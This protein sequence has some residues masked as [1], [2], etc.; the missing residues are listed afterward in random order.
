M[1]KN[2]KVTDYKNN[3]KEIENIDL[4]PIVQE[5]KIEDIKEDKN[6]ESK[7]I[8]SIESIEDA[9]AVLHNGSLSNEEKI[10]ILMTG[11]HSA[12]KLANTLQEYQ[13]KMSKNAVL[14]PAKQMAADN[15]T[16][17]NRLMVVVG[18]VDYSEFNTMFDIVNFFFRVYSKDAFDIFKLC[19]FDMEW[20][21][22]DKQLR[23]YQNLVVIITTLLNPNT[24]STD[25]KTISI[26]TALDRDNTMFNDRASIN[27]RRYYDL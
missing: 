26:N 7:T 2:K 11:S 9:K 3:T 23:T 15:Y 24:R 13:N 25:I 4:Q 18:T 16:L 27:I 19:R 22:G 14:R 1:S 17:Y 8:T 10:K 12:A 5:D 21:W 20:A 6:I